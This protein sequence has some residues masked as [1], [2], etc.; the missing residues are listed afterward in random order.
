MR[1]AVCT[2]TLT[3][4]KFVLS[5]IPNVEIVTLLSALYGYAFGWYGVLSS[6]LFACIEPFLYG[7]GTWV[8]PY[9]LY[10]PLVSAVFFLLRKKNIK[11]RWLLT[12]AALLLTAFFGVLTTFFDIV[13]LVGIR[14]N[15]LFVFAVKYAAGVAFYL[16]QLLTNAVLFPILFPPLAGACACA[17][18]E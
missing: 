18:G 6:F 11:S 12:A 3:A 9:L 1:T 5:S 13:L 16:A 10:W 15:F 14:E 4:G 2:A 8:I 7:V 17:A